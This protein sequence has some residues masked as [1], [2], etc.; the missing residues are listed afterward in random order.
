MMSGIFFGRSLLL[1]S[2]LPSA[3]R[4]PLFMKENLP[5]EV[6]VFSEPHFFLLLC[7]YFIILVILQWLECISNYRPLC[8]LCSLNFFG[9]SLVNSMLLYSAACALQFLVAPDGCHIAPRNGSRSRSRA[10][11]WALTWALTWVLTWALS[12]M[13]QHK[14]N[15]THDR[16][17]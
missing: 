9:L 3:V 14:Y 4:F 16:T 15:L 11:A 12:S 10:W 8:F 6:S 17:R 2:M 1:W 13:L 7:A 5:P